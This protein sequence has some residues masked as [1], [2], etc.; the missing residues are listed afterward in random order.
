MPPPGFAEQP[1]L[2]MPTDDDPILIFEFPFDERAQFEAKSRGYL[3]HV[4][5]QHSP[6]RTYSV[7]FYDGVRLAQDLEY[8]ASSGWMCVAEPGLIILPEVTLE[9]I[10]IAVKKLLAEGFFES[11]RSVE[12]MAAR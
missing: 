6:G 9:N 3:S 1:R 7:V 11:L 5:V 4:R 2:T 12:D 10:R 8:E